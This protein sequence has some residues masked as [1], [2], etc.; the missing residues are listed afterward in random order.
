MIKN[1]SRLALAAFGVSAAFAVA[2]LPLTVGAQPAPPRQLPANPPPPRATPDR[3]PP[4][5]DQQYDRGDP[6]GY[7]RRDERVDRRLDFLRSELRITAAQQRLWDDFANAVREEA[8]QVQA[9]GFDRGPGPGRGGPPPDR[10]DDPRAND[11]RFAP[12]SVVERLQR[13][14]QNLMARVE[15]VDH[16][17]ATLRPLYA[18]FNDEQR[19]IADEEMFRPNRGR[20]DRF[21]MR[22][23]F[24]RDRDRF[25]RPFDRRY[26]P[27]NRPY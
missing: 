2:A 5:A 7:D 11:G 18:S 27:Y 9:R 4:R 22:D 20:F 1:R 25:M 17:L 26:G 14:Q 21:T 23:R 12:P 16:V 24:D 3:P 15:R 13:R 19:R 6:R 10:R 8:D